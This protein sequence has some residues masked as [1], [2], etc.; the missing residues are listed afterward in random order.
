[1]NNILIKSKEKNIEQIFLTVDNINIHAIKLYSKH[2]F[3]VI[4][5]NDKFTTM[6]LHN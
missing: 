2:N 1:M 4:E 5:T 6:L 3:K